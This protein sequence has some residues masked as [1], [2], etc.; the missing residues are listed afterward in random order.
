MCAHD[1]NLLKVYPKAKCPTANDL[2]FPPL[3]L[4]NDNGID[5]F[6]V[7]FI[8]WQPPDFRWQNGCQNILHKVFLTIKALG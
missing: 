3:R 5:K 2:F 8:V 4:K 1:A 7:Y 6:I